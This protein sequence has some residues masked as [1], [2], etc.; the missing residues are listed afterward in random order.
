MSAVDTTAVVLALPVMMKDLHSDIVG[1]VWVIMS[2]LLIITILGTQVG[3]LGDLFGRVKMYNLGFAVFTIG[4]V[5]SGLSA[6]GPELVL[7]R[8]VQGIGGALISA[9]SGA[10]I[11]DTFPENRR[12]RAFGYT[13][14]GWSIGA[15]VGIAIGGAFVTF[16]NWRY[17]FFINLPIGIA[18][19]VAGYYVLKEQSRNPKAKINFIDMAVLGAG[20][21]LVLYA[22][23]QIAGAG[24]SL[25]ILAELAA[26]ACLLGSFVALERY[27]KSPSIETSLFRKKVLTASVSAAFL[28]ALASYAVIFLVIIY[29]QGPRG[30]SPFDA[31]L[32]LIPGY[33]VGGVVAPFAG[34]LTDRFGARVLASIGIALQISGILVYSALTT[35]SAPYY[36]IVGA[37]LNGVGTSIFYPAN[38]SA[39]MRSAPRKSYGV[40]SGVLRTLSNTGMVSSFAV[41]LFVASLSIPRQTAFSI[42]LGVVSHISGR[43][44]NAYVD[45]MH[46][47]LLTSISLLAVALVL[48]VFRGSEST[49]SKDAK[50]K[51]AERRDDATG[52]S[53]A[54]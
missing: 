48:S 20:L 41:A 12:G 54:A 4:S 50:E 21:F 27:M 14:I 47:A 31:S 51:T 40:A 24:T 23:T 36:V 22:V 29:L 26:G 5:L 35:Q 13:A 25:I 38:T 3:R 17:I 2:Y 28:Q 10:M 37:V 44:S 6:T 7:F 53:A 8:L 45:G 11:A 19:T 42:F 9:N 33:V 43:L 39:V 49:V 46:S 18:A 16:L 1:M 15:I 32:L 52:D 30:M 34:R